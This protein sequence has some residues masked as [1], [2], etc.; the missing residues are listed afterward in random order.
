MYFYI[1]NIL[2][3]LNISIVT[4]II[5]LN[6]NEALDTYLLLDESGKLIKDKYTLNF[7]EEKI[8]TI[9]A[10]QIINLEKLQKTS[11]KCS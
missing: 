1:A 11:S 9:F 4:R 6:N 8:N 5:T 7:L 10:D 2:D 3:N